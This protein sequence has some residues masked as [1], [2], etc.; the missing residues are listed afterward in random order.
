MTGL[1]TIAL[2]DLRLAFRDRAAL[3]LMLAAP[4]A[5]TLGLGVVTG[6][7]SGGDTDD[8]VALDIPV[9]IVNHDDG[10]LGQALVDVFTS[11]GLEALVRP[12]TATA[13]DTARR[14]VA[15]DAAAAAVIIPAGFTTASVPAADRAT[16]SVVLELHAN[17]AR[18][19]S[20]GVVQSIVEQFLSRIEANRVR[21]QVAIELLLADGRIR[22]SDIAGVG[23]AVAERDVGAPQTIALER[24]SASG[25]P[26]QAFDPLYLLAPAMAMLFLMYTVTRGGALLLAERDGGTLARLLISPISTTHVLSGKVAGIFLT[27]LAQVAIL[28]AASTL[29]FGLRWGDPA[30]LVLLVPAVALAATGWGLLLTSF[31]KTPQQAGSLGAAVMLLFGVLGRSFGDSIPF[32]GF[33]QAAGLVTPN[34]W[35]IQGFTALGSGGSAADIVPNV[36]ALL[37]IAAVTFAIAVVMFHRNGFV[38]R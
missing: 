28:I 11:P 18:P 29:L 16:G 36:L 3:I 15:D 25:R 2:N 34:A 21:G 26:A 12:M 32:P 9:V 38:T 14:L 7:L 33:L 4:F 1:I 22:A 31:V 5:L 10:Q 20:A 8:A 35:G 19:V 24:T 37:A 23:Q 30:G 13:A 6:R 27:A 17:T